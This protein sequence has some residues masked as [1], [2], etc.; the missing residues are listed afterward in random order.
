M[1]RYEQLV[2]CR[3]SR[4]GGRSFL[5]CLAV[6]ASNVGPLLAASKEGKVDC[7]IVR[8][9]AVPSVQV[10]QFAAARTLHNLTCG[11]MKARTVNAELVY[12]LCPVRSIGEAFRRFGVPADSD[13]A[14]SVVVARLAREDGSGPDALSCSSLLEWEAAVMAAGE[15]IDVLPAGD[16]ADFLSESCAAEPGR[17]AVVGA[18]GLL[19]EDLLHST[20]EDACILVIGSRE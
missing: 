11:A 20:L 15:G 13:E 9:P 1:E 17:A 10:L 12:S 2:P 5:D 4:G 8:V 6:R 16:I 7:A 19:E 18:F 3:A 14:H